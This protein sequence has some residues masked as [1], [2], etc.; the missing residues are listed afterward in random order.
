MENTHRLFGLFAILLVLVAVTYFGC[1]NSDDDDSNDDD[2]DD[3]SSAEPEVGTYYRYFEDI[4]SGCSFVQQVFIIRDPSYCD[5]DD[6]PAMP[7]PTNYPSSAIEV[8]YHDEYSL[9]QKH[10]LAEVVQIDGSDC[11]QGFSAGVLLSEDPDGER[12][13]ANGGTVTVQRSND[14]E[15]E[16]EFDL[17]FEDGSTQNG[18]WIGKVCGEDVP[19]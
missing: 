1:N 9:E 19:E 8:Y 17:E 18:F 4:D 12:Y 3:D 10:S 5:W 15:F 14:S 7:K 11:R 16:V 6:D 13:S 2:V